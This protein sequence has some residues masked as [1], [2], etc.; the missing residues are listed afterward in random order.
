[1]KREIE[2]YFLK[3]ERPPL[4]LK[5]REIEEVDVRKRKIEEDYPK[6]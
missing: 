1:M 6:K 2:G 3:R 4:F 5:K